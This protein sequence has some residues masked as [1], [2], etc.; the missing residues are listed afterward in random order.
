MLSSGELNERKINP[1]IK[2][3]NQMKQQKKLASSGVYYHYHFICI[4]DH[5][6][7]GSAL[8]KIKNTIKSQKLS[9]EHFNV[10]FF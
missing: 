1:K 2:K 8:H 7:Y 4:F 10:F 3:T 6:Q 9:P 5:Y